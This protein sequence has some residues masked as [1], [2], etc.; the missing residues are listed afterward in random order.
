MAYE[1]VKIRDIV[2]RAVNHSWSIPEFQRGFVWK[3][4]QVRDL[5]ESLWYD[6]PIGTLLVWNG[7]GPAEEQHAHDAQRPGLWVV[8]GQQRSSALCILFGRKPYWWSSVDEWNKTLRK[9]DIRFDV[10][11][12]EPPFFW[13]ANAVIRKATGSRY[14]PLRDLLNLD[15]SREKDQKALQDLAKQIKIEGLCDGLDAMEVYTRLDRIR[16]IRDKDLVAVTIDHELEDVVEIFSRLNSRGTRVTE[17]DIYLGVVAARN[18]GWVRDTF[19]PYLRSLAESGF[20]LDPN[21]L[22]RTVT[23]VGA[24][25]VRFRETPDSFWEPKSIHPAWTK[26]AEAWKRLIARFREYGILSSDPMPTQAALV[27]MVSLVDKFNDSSDFRFALYWF[28]QASRFGRYSGSGTTSLE[29][30]LRDVQEAHSLTDAVHRLLRR[31]PHAEPVSE[32]E[33]LRDY[34]D[35]RFGRFFLYLLVY[36]NKAQNWDEHGHRIGFE[37]MAVLSDFRPQWHHVF[38]TKFL[39][40]KVEDRLIDALA[41]IAVIG[42]E[43]NI[44]ISAKDPMSYIAKYKITPEKLAQQFIEPA[45]VSVSHEGYES[46]LRG[47]AKRLA[48]VG[49]EF[50]AEL[51]PPASA[52]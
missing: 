43:I 22:F 47:R 26:T 8:D 32:E 51:A 20:D 3:A 4:T 39:E 46:W 21:L 30:D 18:P 27:I 23:G 13:V 10:N 36:R 28:L 42:P 41:K 37:G 29:E 9:F 52:G 17:A 50:L 7:R 49:N 25:K 16:K 35:S 5:A 19:L 45:S 6:Y 11:A 24:K 44:R 31:F 2:D 48:E 33:F 14:V 40:G 38:P 12:K 15:T 34:A 1:Q